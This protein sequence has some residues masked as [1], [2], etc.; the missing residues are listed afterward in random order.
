MIDTGSFAVSE[1]E[2]S[3]WAGWPVSGPRTL[4]WCCKFMSEHA[5]H[6]LARHP[7]SV[8]LSGLLATDPAAQEHEWLCRAI[9]LGLTFDQ[10]QGAELSCLELL[11]RRLQMLEMKHRDK[12]A[13]SFF[14]SSIEEDSHMARLGPRC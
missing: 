7:R 5:L 6:P 8:Q 3:P 14:G 4:L 10:L 1:L 9:E 2:Q 12:V 11:A 13:G